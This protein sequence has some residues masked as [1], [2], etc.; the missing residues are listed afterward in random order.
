M[1]VIVVLV[2]EVEVIV[3]LVSE[4]DIVV[5]VGEVYIVV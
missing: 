5:L 3:V 2:G 4:V 1:E